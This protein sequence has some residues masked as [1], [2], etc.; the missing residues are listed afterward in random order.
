MIVD[1]FYPEMFHKIFFTRAPS[2]FA[3]TWSIAKNF[4]GEVTREK[5]EILGS[6]IST[7][8]LLEVLPCD[9]VPIFLG[10]IIN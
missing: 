7:R 5:I 2:M 6:K 8:R 1:P 4:F 3:A 10:G 9:V